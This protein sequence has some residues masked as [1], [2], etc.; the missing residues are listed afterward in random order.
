MLPQ[1][2]NKEKATYKI[3]EHDIL[4]IRILS[5]NKEIAELYNNIPTRG[6]NTTLSSEADQYV[7]GFTVGDKGEIS[8]PILGNLKVSDFTLQEIER[9]IQKRA[10]E[11]LIDATVLVRF[12]DYKVTVLGEVTRPGVYFNYNDQLTIFEILGKA[13]DINEF[14]DKRHI[15]ILRPNETE[16]K[17]YEIDITKKDILSSSG[18]YLMPNDIVYVKPSKNKAFRVNLPI[19]NLALSSATT[20]L[21]LLQFFRNK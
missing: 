21:L 4:F 6:M 14:G 12:L 16:T 2:F 10:D 18:F 8:L 20:V 17:T 13:G 15:L 1:S 7:N 19:W 3:K 9:M 5:S 11:Y